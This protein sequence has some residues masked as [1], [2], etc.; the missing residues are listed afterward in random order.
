MNKYG[1][2]G[3]KVNVGS[4]GI[5]DNNVTTTFFTLYRTTLLIPVRGE[6]AYNQQQ[7]ALYHLTFISMQDVFPLICST[8]LI[9]RH[10]QDG[11]K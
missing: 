10:C 3:S 5:I 2:Y 6:F 11:T 1:L 8:C 4:N 9:Y 7:I